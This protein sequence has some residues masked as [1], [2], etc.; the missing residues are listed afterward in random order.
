MRSPSDGAPP[1]AAAGTG[2]AARV[3]V[4]LDVGGTK[5]LGVRLG[6]GA[7]VEEELREPTAP[8][9]GLVAQLA[10]MA[11]RLVPGGSGAR[12]RLALGV[13]LPG[14]V[15]GGGVLRFAPN[16]VGLEGV[17]VR[18]GLLER[19]APLLAPVVAPRGGSGAAL[20]VD[21]DATCA[22]AAEHAVG[23]ARGTRDALVVTL[24]T[25]I[26]GGIVAGGRLVRGAHNF[27]GEV[28]HMV[29]E[30]DGLP[31]PC[32]KRGCWERYASGSALARLG[33]EALEA[34]RGG[35]LEELAGGNAAAVRGE[36]VVEAA[37][38]GDAVA[39]ELLRAL[40]WWLA[41]G[42]SNLAGI[43]D[44]ER[45]VVGGGL[46]AAG[47]MLLAP[48]RAAFAEQLEGASRRPEVPVVAATLGERAGAIG[49]ALL[50]AGAFEVPADR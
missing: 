44:P 46:V 7:A 11:T 19:L 21:N 10:S 45:I 20:V 5:V 4:G 1:A 42:L 2:A 3:L 13:G 32:G 43:L 15:D 16:V 26:G 41:L 40:G 28:G 36:D 48:L 17:A 31:C 18:E 38:A 29:V 25:G 37:R 9:E 12:A 8:A 50:A 39:G 22:A 49:A 30:A 24:G 23:A 47:E 33:R 6:A 27:A 14:L 34:G 35:R